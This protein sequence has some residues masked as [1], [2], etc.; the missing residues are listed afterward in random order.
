[1]L[2][3]DF[4]D[5]IKEYEDFDFD[6]YNKNVTDD[7][8]K[9]SLSKKDRSINDL[10]NLLSDRAENFLE[11]IARKSHNETIQYFGRTIQLYI[12]LYISNYCSNECIYCGFNHKNQIKRLQLNEDEIREQMKIISHTKMK[13]LLLLTGEAPGLATVDYII[14]AVE[15]AKEY[16]SS[17]SI[18]VYPM[19]TCDYRRLKES[20]VDGLTVYQEVYDREV[21]K[22]VHLKGKK[23]DY[24]FRILTPERGAEAGFRM[25]GIGPL[26]GLAS[27]Y[28]EA[29][30]CAL[31]A[32]YLQRKYL[33][34]E[35]SISLPRINNAEG[36]YLAK[37][38]LTDKKFVQYMSA[39]RLFLPRIGITVST[40][41]N[42]E[43]R[44]NV[45]PLGVTRFSAESNTQVGGYSSD[46]SEETPQ[47][48]ISDARSTEEIVE[49]VE[50]AGYQIIYK[51]WELI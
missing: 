6:T 20:G 15:I 50:N 42:A 47:F 45:L 43:F 33:D 7:D 18:E 21:Y 44:N 48:E 24:D 34:T 11:E 1:M 29:F 12:P 22:Q 35:I 46:H 19:E 9:K 36:A 40:R 2:N 31:H 4:R 3:G 41:E 32:D 37:Y 5:I 38:P 14:K 30:F 28:R 13:H 26:F 16:F 27:T 39:F 51:D 10:L 17:I 8:I 23:R 25:I 49:F